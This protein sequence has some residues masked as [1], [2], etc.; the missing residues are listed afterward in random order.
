[1]PGDKPLFWKAFD[2]AERAVGPRL[3][4]AV[5][6]GA[7][8]DALG[9]AARV[10]AR[11]RRDVEKRSR[12]LLHL[13]NLPAASDVAHLRRQIA[14]LDRDLRRLTAAVE[15]VEEEHVDRPGPRPPR[16]RAQR[17]QGS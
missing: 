17:S 12:G 13:V 5:R 16:R 7:F 4:E 11:V 14:Q 15:R 3:E 8:L 1:M 10:Q 6:S 2:V 9:V